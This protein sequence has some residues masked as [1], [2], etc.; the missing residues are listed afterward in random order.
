[1]ILTKD[2]EKA[3]LKLKK[4]FFGYTK[5]EDLKITFHLG[6]VNGEFDDIYV[7]QLIND[8]NFEWAMGTIRRVTGWAGSDFEELDKNKE[9]YIGNEFTCTVRHSTYKDYNNYNLE[10]NDYK[11][12]DLRAA[13]KKF[14]AKLLDYAAKHN[15]PM[16]IKPQV[17]NSSQANDIDIPF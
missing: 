5:K 17:N 1:M 14:Q 11:K 13:T 8:D 2:I 6:F 16:E 15:E 10:F 7:S 3:N 9:L 12:V 4:F